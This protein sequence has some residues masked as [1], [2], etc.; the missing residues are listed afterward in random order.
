MK[1]LIIALFVGFT[2]LFVGACK[3]APVNAKDESM[4]ESVPIPCN[5][6][7]ISAYSGGSG[8]SMATRAFRQGEE[9][10]T[11]F[12]RYGSG[13][14]GMQIREHRCTNQDR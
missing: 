4:S 14:V 11:I 3:R 12:I 7:V 8:F 10:E 5:Q 1:K 2:L 9:P 13:S 6:K